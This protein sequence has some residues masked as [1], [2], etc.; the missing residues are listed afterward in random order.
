MAGK[1]LTKVERVKACLLQ[2]LQGII[3]I[4]AFDVHQVNHVKELAILISFLI[5]RGSVML[6]N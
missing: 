3:E 1:Y 4:G 6:S 2:L 5:L